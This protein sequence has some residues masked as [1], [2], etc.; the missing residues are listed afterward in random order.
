MLYNNVKSPSV[1]L[2]P[3][4]IATG[5]CR[6]IININGKSDTIEFHYK[7]YPHLISKEC[8][9]TFY[10]DLYSDSLFYTLH[11]IDSIKIIK[12]TVTNINEE[13]IRIYY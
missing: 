4:N 6:Y 10:H 1:A 7:S 8:G 9:Y 3:L 2:L 5:N 11:Q 13:N 12:N